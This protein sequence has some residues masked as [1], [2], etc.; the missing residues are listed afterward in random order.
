MKTIMKL[1]KE[2]GCTTP[3]FAGSLL[4][5]VYQERLKFF[6]KHV[7]EFGMNYSSRLVLDTRQIDFADR[8][9]LRRFL[10][11]ID[12]IITTDDKEACR[13]CKM[14]VQLGFCVPEEIAITGINNIPN[15]DIFSPGITTVALDTENDTGQMIDLLMKRIENGEK[16]QAESEIQLIKRDSA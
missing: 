8:K 16:F 1:L 15:L 9:M 7:A 4:F 14:A 10:G 3:A 2:R 12:S 6:R 11:E 13:F 5:P